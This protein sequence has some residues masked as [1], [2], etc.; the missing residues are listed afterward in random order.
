MQ[1]FAFIVY[2]TTINH[3]LVLIEPGPAL[4]ALCVYMLAAPVSLLSA[5]VSVGAAVEMNQAA[6]ATP[7]P[8]EP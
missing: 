4:L 1:F 7:R 8:S 2:V 3:Q 6:G 5:H